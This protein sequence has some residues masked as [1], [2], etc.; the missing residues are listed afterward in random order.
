MKR[1]VKEIASDFR[2][3]YE[4]K[5][6]ENPKILP[7]GFLRAVN[8][9]ENKWGYGFLTNKDAVRTILDIWD[10][11]DEWVWKHAGESAIKL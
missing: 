11:C 1:Y 3:D 2:K 8:E 7:A 6:K 10:A 5:C 4:Q 9:V